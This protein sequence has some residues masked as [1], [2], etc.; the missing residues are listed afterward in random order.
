MTDDGDESKKLT[1]ERVAQEAAG[2]PRADEAPKV[3]R[4]L[5]NDCLFANELGDGILYATLFRGRFLYAKST[6]TWYE[7]NGNY[8]QQD[9][10]NRSLAAVEDVV[11]LY[12]GEY[13]KISSEVS[14]AIAKGADAKGD[15]IK[16]LEG[17]Q[18]RLLKRASA[19]RAAGKRRA[20]CLEF[21]HTLPENPLAIKGE[22]FDQQPWLF[23]CANGVLDLRTGL[24]NPGVP[25]DYLSLASPIEFLGIDYP[26]PLWEKSLLEIFNGKKEMVAYM[27]RLLGYCITGIVNQKVFPVLYGRTGWNGRSLIVETVNYVMGAMAATIQ[28]EMRLSQRFSKSSSGP[29]PDIMSLKGIRLSFASEIEENQQFSTAKIKKLTGKNTLVGRHPNDK[30]EV[31]FAPTQKIMIETNIQPSAPANDRSFWERMHLIPFDISFVNRDPIEA[32]ERRAIMDLDDQVRKEAP[33]ILAWLLRGCLFWQ[34]QGLMPPQE[35]TNAAAEYR[36]NED[37]L[38][39]FIEA[40]CVLTPAAKV[41]SKVIYQRYIAWYKENVDSREKKEPTITAFGK[42]LGRVFEKHRVNGIVEYIGIDVKDAPPDDTQL[43]V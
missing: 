11:A 5:I 6:T 14:D 35:V 20:A 29:S 19:L 21:A 34:Q 43:G 25:G 10:M 16:K 31:R 9:V 1:E 22:E 39:D 28:S 37:L 27:Q 33:G 38:G 30:Y 36:R 7:W 12:L 42:Q 17:Q 4:K 41:L 23:P 13:K 8:W 2:I 32:H 15:P 3:T 26:A 40:C 18:D 24:L